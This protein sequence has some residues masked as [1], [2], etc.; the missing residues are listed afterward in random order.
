MLEYIHPER[1]WVRRDYWLSEP[2]T[3]N[4]R[5]ALRSAI[6]LLDALRTP[7]RVVFT[8]DSRYLIDGITSWVHG[9][10]RR[11]W[12]RKGGAIENLELWKGLVRSAARHDVQW[13]WVKGHAGHAQNEYANHLAT[14]AAAE[15]SESGGLSPSGFESWLEAERA[16]GRYHE[17]HPPETTDSEF[18]PST[19]PPIS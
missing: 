17:F 10:S 3:T 11:G 4:N 1:G 13:V 9:W 2:D 16:R 6:E 12:T 18:R 19:L 7:A 5:M 14:R 15:Q 8:S